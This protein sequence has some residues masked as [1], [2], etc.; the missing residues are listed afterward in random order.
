MPRLPRPSRRTILTASLLL[1]AGAVMNVAVA[2]V[3]VGAPDSW[4]PAGPRTIFDAYE[5]PEPV[6]AERLPRMAA[7]LGAPQGLPP[8]VAGVIR[9]GRGWTQTFVAIASDE[10][11]L[12][13]GVGA[14]G[15]WPARS[16]VVVK[17]MAAPSWDE[18]ASASFAPPRRL[19]PGSEWFA[20]ERNRVPLAPVF[21][22]FLLNT[23]FYA[24][25]VGSILVPPLSFFP[26]RRRLRARRGRARKCG[27]DR[28]GLAAAAPCPQRGAAR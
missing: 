20:G 5:V 3:L 21:P 25:V 11:R 14:E 9:R 4:T 10:G 8:P 16:M 17:S 26:I 19:L 12:W 1:L 28:A 15:G 7:H 13:Y 24:L 2:W 18:T 22:G 6:T 23:L 27:C